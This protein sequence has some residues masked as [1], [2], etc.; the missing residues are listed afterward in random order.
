MPKSI[1]VM[2]RVSRGFWDS[3]FYVVVGDSAVFVNRDN[4]RVEQV[5]DTN[6]EVDGQVLAL[7]I[8]QEPDKFLVELPGEPVIG[9]LRSW[10]PRT[11]LATA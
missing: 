7:V 10:V 3:E 11:A 4:V 9:G 5:P 2:C 1:Y 6:T 8:Q